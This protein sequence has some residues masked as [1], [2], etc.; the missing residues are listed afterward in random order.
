M[1]DAVELW[2]MSLCAASVF[3]VGAWVWSRRAL[4]ARRAGLPAPAYALRRT[5][6]AL[7]A[8]YVLGCAFRSWHPMIDA[9]RLCLHDAWGASIVVG[10]SVATVAELCFAAQWMLILREAGAAAGHRPTTLMAAALLPLIAL[11]EVASWYAVLTTDYLFHALENTLWT[12]AALGVVASFLGVRATVDDRSRRFVDTVVACGLAYVAFMAI[13][14]VPMY[15]GRWVADV[16]AAKP[17]LTLAEGWREVV[18]PCRIVTAWEA[19]DEDVAW[20]SLY[21]TAA[22]WI[23]VALPHV[24]GLG[25]R[26]HETRA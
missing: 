17:L 5:V 14:D 9:P 20:L 16:A 21:F 18:A 19:W 23:S 6:L 1:P 25:R 8:I 11:A 13:V 24:P 26:R 22:V 10:R 2:W 7:G 12:L 3:N 15:L 4:H